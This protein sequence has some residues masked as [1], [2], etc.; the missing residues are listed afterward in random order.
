MNQAGV[1]HSSAKYITLLAEEPLEQDLNLEES[2]VN[3]ALKGTCPS[4]SEAVQPS[5]A[6]IALENLTEQVRELKDVNARLMC[7][8]VEKNNEVKALRESQPKSVDPSELNATGA[9]VVELAKAKRDVTA[10]YEAE[11]TKV[12]KLLQEKS[13]LQAHNE[14]LEEKLRQFSLPKEAVPEK[15]KTSISSSS[16]SIDRHHRR[17]TALEKC[18]VATHEAT[19]LKQNNAK[20]QRL[21]ERELGPDADVNLLLREDHP[22][23][24]GRDEQI[25]LLKVSRII[26]ARE[27]FSEITEK[28]ASLQKS[29]TDARSKLTAEKARNEYLSKENLRL[30]QF[31]KHVVE[32]CKKDAEL[33]QYFQTTITEL[34]NAVQETSPI[35][36]P[37]IPPLKDPPQSADL[38][39]KI[40]D[41]EKQIQELK[42]TNHA[43]INSVRNTKVTTSLPDIIAK[44]GDCDTISCDS[45]TDLP[46]NSLDEHV[47]RN[48]H[49]DAGLFTPFYETL[50]LCKEYVEVL[51]DRL[52]KAESSWQFVTDEFN[53]EREASSVLQLQ[54]R[55][56]Q[57]EL[58][59]CS[60][61]RRRGFRRTSKSHET[62]Q[63]GVHV[64]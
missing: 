42:L 50:R 61:E 41:M 4:V 56:Y 33:I 49:M 28:N 8:I 60:V 25:Q 2:F 47:P 52:V 27:M 43:C 14:Q 38:Q 48:A 54:I 23:F 12:Q 13:A 7:C 15:V 46:E 16:S 40:I 11:R 58:E 5:M 57:Q 51:S 22:T 59:Q 39:K 18:S 62:V 9:K 17:Q 45:L 10:K 31:N 21:L 44:R 64:Q 6:D 36:L 29:L 19:L 53:I 24:R 26:R 20:L 63:H 32:T 3:T 37:L 1:S 35:T 34:R 30:T 55:H